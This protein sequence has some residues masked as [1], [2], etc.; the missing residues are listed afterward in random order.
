LTGL[1]PDISV[2]FF[3]LFFRRRVKSNFN[4]RE[5]VY[6]AGMR[7]FPLRVGLPDRLWKLAADGLIDKIALGL[8]GHV[9]HMA[10]DV[11]ADRFEPGRGGVPG[12]VKGTGEKVYDP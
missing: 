3:I 12:H 5:E 7:P 8:M 9:L 4:F 11:R 6:A 1:L 10:L 2:A